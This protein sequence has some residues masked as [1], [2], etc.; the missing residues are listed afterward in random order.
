MKPS[1][2]FPQTRW[3]LVLA[4]RDSNDCRSQSALAE[5][6]QTYWYPLYAHARRHGAS[7]EDAEDLTQAF[8]QGVIKNDVFARIDPDGGRLRSYLL[9][10]MTRFLASDERKRKALKRGGGQT[11]VSIDQARA[12]DRYQMEPK[13][14]ASPETL[15]ERRWAQVLFE[16]VFQSLQAE[17]TA[18]GRS[19]EFE[20]MQPMLMPGAREISHRDLSK[21]IGSSESAART[22]LF[23]L[24]QRFGELL[25]RAIADTV[26]S[27]DDVADEIAHLMKV[28][29]TETS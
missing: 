27:E 7:P 18:K 17:S 29:Q 3:S 11:V 12:E 1:P 19:D 21:K 8:F 10:S 16:Q 22:A 9:K 2:N 5:L 4:T 24:R 23:R 13:D 25:R 6:C 28:F 20:A 15:Y 26:S 14:S